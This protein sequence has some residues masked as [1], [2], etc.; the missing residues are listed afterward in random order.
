MLAI[1]APENGPAVAPVPDSVPAVDVHITGVSLGIARADGIANGKAVAYL[2]PT[3]RF[4]AKVAGGEP[5][6]IEVIALDPA[7][8]TIAPPAVPVPQPLAGKE[9]QK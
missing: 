7:S 9:V 3:Y 8:F 4:H 6:D 5:Y 2:V 1:A